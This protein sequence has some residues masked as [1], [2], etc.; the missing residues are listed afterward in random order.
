MKLSEVKSGHS[1]S[2]QVSQNNLFAK[3]DQLSICKTGQKY[4]VPGFRSPHRSQV[5]KRHD[6]G[7][8]LVGHPAQHRAE[9]GL[10]P[11]G[12]H[13]PPGF[14]RQLRWKHPGVNFTNIL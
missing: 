7:L 4:N 5:G 8:Q 3:L 12:D 1:E 6:R 13:D 14:N 9:R 2:S 10:D 11:G